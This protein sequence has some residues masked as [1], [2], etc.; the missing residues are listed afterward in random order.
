MRRKASLASTMRC[1][2]TIVTPRMLA[3]NSAR[4]SD[5]LSAKCSARSCA[6]PPIDIGGQ[7]RQRTAQG[8]GRCVVSRHRIGRG[9]PGRQAGGDMDKD[10]R[11]RLAAVTLVAFGAV[12]A[13]MATLALG[14]TTAADVAVTRFATDFPVRKA[15]GP[16]GVAFDRAHRLYVSDRGFL[17][18]FGPNGG[19][20][21][22]HQLNTRPLR[23]FVTGM[24]FGKSGQLFAARWTSG[25]R[26]DVVQLNP[27][28]GGVVRQVASGIDCPTGLS[29][30]PVSG[31]IFV[32]EVWCIPQVLRISGGQVSPYVAGV[33]TDG[34]AFAP[35]GTLYLA[36]Q[37][38]VDGYTISAVPA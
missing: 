29:V 8:S 34:L 35:D 25:R 26:G 27:D 31:D 17:Y 9:C 10:F 11:L 3:S 18:R 20:A 22:A 2:S 37:P 13:I 16:T 24:A 32:S 21:S 23:G 7:Y 36:H 38:D 15:M 12:A 6:A 19:I 4:N 28:T 1:S 33:H 5:S 30:D 14:S